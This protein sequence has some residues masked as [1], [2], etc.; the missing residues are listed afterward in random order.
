MLARHIQNELTNSN[1]NYISQLKDF[2][3]NIQ[4]PTNR[5][6]S[7][8]AQNLTLANSVFFIGRDRDY[9][10]SEEAS[11]KLKEITYINSSAYPSGELKHGFLALI[12]SNTYLFVIATQ[13][14]LLDKTLNGA[15]EALS[16]GVKI[17]LI[18]QFNIP[19]DRFTLL[20]EGMH[21]DLAKKRY[22]TFE[23]LDWYLYRV[24]VIVGKATLDILGLTGTHANE[25][26]YYLGRAVQLTNIVRDV[27][28]DAR[29]GR[30]YL[31][32]SLSAQDILSGTHK[33]EVKKLLQQAAV[34]AHECY[35][36]AF[37]FMDY[38]WPTKM[39]PCRIMGYTYQKNL[40]KIE[41]T[42][43]SFTRTVKLG[44]LEKLQMVFY[45]IIKTLF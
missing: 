17:I 19:K 43:F 5:K 38:F 37:G 34:R 7:Q 36:R 25:L 28:D 6:I 32:C 1:F 13:K 22:A 9:I 15:N 23:E 41:K 45:A 4:I 2:A 40:A 35:T 42:G 21:A 30:V 8:I 33:A 18:T 16:R 11:L 27:Y 3:E 31:P 26:A 20:L 14:S 24:A 10:S 29:L 39:L 12:D 44:K